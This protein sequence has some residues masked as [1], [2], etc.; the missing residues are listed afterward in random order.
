LLLAASTFPFLRGGEDSTVVIMWLTSIAALFMAQLPGARA[1]LHIVREEA[2][3]LVGLAAVLLIALAS[4]SYQLT[5][6]PYN[7]DGDFAAV[8]LQARALATGAQE[9][10]FAMVG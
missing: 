8:G 9:Q 7:L 5:T 2:W 3:Y 6:L 1:L 10:I 4:R